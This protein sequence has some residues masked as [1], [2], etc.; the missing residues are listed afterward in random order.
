[1]KGLDMN[2]QQTL[3]SIERQVAWRILYLGG[4]ASFLMFF[5]LLLINGQLNL[6]GLA[7]FELGKET[8]EC[9]MKVELFLSGLVFF[10]PAAL[11]ALLLCYLG[12][13]ANFTLKVD[14]ILRKANPEDDAS[15]FLSF[16]ESCKICVKQSKSNG[17]IAVVLLAL[18]IVALVNGFYKSSHSIEPD[19]GYTALCVSAALVLLYFMCSAK[20]AWIVPRQ[21]NLY[22]GLE[23]E[24]NSLAHRIAK[25]MPLGSDYKCC[26][27]DDLNFYA[28]GFFAAS[29]KRHTEKLCEIASKYPQ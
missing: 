19:M 4:A 5:G 9:V 8:L 14:A 20:S 25:N 22:E 11:L 13:N 17:L 28:L 1:M 12:I 16:E 26:A 29:N 24:V 23:G 10:W 15:V 21:P 7:L 27:L 18:A 6:A 2:N 3:S